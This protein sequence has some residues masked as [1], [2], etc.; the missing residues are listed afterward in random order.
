VPLWRDVLIIRIADY[1]A[2]SSVITPKLSV[3]EAKKRKGFRRRGYVAC[4]CGEGC[5]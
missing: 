1:D 2:H 4:C 3:P 5:A